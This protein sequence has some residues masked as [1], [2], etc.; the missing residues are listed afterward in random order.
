MKV[1]GFKEKS[2]SRVENYES[3][4]TLSPR[5]DRDIP[6]AAAAFRMELYSNNPD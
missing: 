6:C 3:P 4:H 5:V 2:W 1:S